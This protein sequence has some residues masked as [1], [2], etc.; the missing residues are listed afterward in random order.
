MSSPQCRYVLDV[1]SALLCAPF[2]ARLIFSR[3]QR[4]R[5]A[6]LFGREI[7]VAFGI[8]DAAL[9]VAPLCLRR[10]E[11]P[12]SPCGV[13]Q[14]SAQLPAVAALARERVVPRPIAGSLQR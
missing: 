4:V 11:K 8:A 12:L 2:V 5:A 14:E 6:S 10:P 1:L 9:D 3:D 13:E 7:E